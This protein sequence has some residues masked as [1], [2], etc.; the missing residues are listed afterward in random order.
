MF[1]KSDLWL[2][3]NL[4]YTCYIWTL[5]PT[6]AVP[7]NVPMYIHSLVFKPGKHTFSQMLIFFPGKNSQMCSFWKWAVCIRASSNSSPEGILQ[8]L[9][10]RININS[11]VQHEA[12]ISSAILM[13]KCNSIWNDSLGFSN[14]RN[15]ST[16]CVPHYN[17]SGFKEW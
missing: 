1:R 9:A 12:E 5:I 7:C 3:L 2:I 13:L 16:S 8:L 11:W 17:G 15:S 6:D 10:P 4:A 14:N